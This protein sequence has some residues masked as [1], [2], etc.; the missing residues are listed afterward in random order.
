MNLSASSL[1]ALGKH[2]RFRRF[3]DEGVII[4]QENAEALV[5]NDS[6]A[7]LLELTDGSRSLKDCAVTIAAEYEAGLETIER[8]LV[9]F[10]AELVGA[11]IVTIIR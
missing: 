3:D 2:V 6:G 11:G 10:A 1:L 9:R 4:H 5:V 8:D 7:R